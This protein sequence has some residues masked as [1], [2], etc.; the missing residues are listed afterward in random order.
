LPIS[1]QPKILLVE[2]DEVIVRSVLTQL[3]DHVRIFTAD[4]PE[5]AW[6]LFQLHQDSLQIIF[7]GGNLRQGKN[8][9]GLLA[10]I[11]MVEFPGKVI[12]ITEDVSMRQS[13]F[14]QAVE[15]DP[16]Q[17]VCDGHV[18]K[19]KLVRYILDSIPPD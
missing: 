8:S 15:P 16:N 11:R 13:M 6:T 1:K 19:N 18:S 17:P 7:L 14:P 9:L 3:R 5:Q 12:S 2:D 4:T 10:R